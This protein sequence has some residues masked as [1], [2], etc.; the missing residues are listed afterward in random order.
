[1]LFE[2]VSSPAHV[3]HKKMGLLLMDIDESWCAFISC[4]LLLRG[5]FFSRTP[6]NNESVQILAAARGRLQA[7]TNHQRSCCASHSSPSS[8]PACAASVLAHAPERGTQAGELL[9]HIRSGP[10]TGTR[11]EDDDGDDASEAD[12]VAAQRRRAGWPSWSHEARYRYLLRHR[13]FLY[14]RRWL[15]RHATVVRWAQCQATD[16]LDRVRDLWFRDLRDHRRPP[17]RH[18]IA[19]GWT[20]PQRRT[21]AC[22]RQR[23]RWQRMR[24]AIRRSPWPRAQ[25]R[26]RAA[27]LRRE[28]R[29]QACAE[30]RVEVRAAAD[31]RYWA[32]WHEALDAAVAD[33]DE[34]DAWRIRTGH[35][36]AHEA[37]HEQ[38]RTHAELAAAAE[39]VE[40]AIEAREEH[41]MEREERRVLFDV[42]QAGWSDSTF[43]AEWVRQQEEEEEAWAGDGLT[44]VEADDRLEGF[45][46][47]F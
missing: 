40:A 24:A 46:E 30:A 29:E 5:A 47:G 6:D 15:I 38:L 35:E 17:M 14:C 2:R 7:A 18:W 13:N 41:R 32:E 21:A 43:A 28:A 44:V 3:L 22:Q 27:R 25:A 1:M 4:V 42:L 36:A 9:L 20:S 16:Q 12:D 39:A 19:H 45:A 11:S 33:G 37:T 8:A 23:D 31:A 26:E 10:A 34:E